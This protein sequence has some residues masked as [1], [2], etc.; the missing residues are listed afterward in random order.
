VRHV[1]LPTTSQRVWRAI[2]QA[3]EGAR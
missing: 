1:D 3:R 2:H